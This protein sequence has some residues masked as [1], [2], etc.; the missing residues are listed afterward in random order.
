MSKPGGIC[1]Q[2]YRCKCG[3]ETYQAPN[4]W[5]EHKCSPTA[6]QSTHLK[7]IIA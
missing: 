4:A 6:R 3:F 5:V 1:T 2:L 7:A